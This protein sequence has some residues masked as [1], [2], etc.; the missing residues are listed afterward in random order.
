MKQLIWL[1]LL[2]TAQALGAAVSIQVGH[3]NWHDVDATRL[4]WTPMCFIQPTPK[5]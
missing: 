4:A 3:A 1:S 5:R 2:F